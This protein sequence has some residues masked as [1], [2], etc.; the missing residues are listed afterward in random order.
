MRDVPIVIHALPNPIEKCETGFREL[1]SIQQPRHSIS[2]PQPPTTIVGRPL[3]TW[4]K[5]GIAATPIELAV[6]GVK[7][8][9]FI[10]EMRNQASELGKGVRA[11]RR[12][13]VTVRGYSSHALAPWLRS[14]SA[15]AVTAAR[16]GSPGEV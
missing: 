5:F 10:V 3:K 11:T 7:I 14:P 8:E 16:G 6:Y 1:R 13:G 12:V 2:E 15:P 4:G 9:I